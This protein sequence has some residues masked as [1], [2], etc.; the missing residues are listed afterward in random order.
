MEVKFSGGEV[1][2]AKFGA[3]SFVGR[4]SC[5]RS[6][7]RRLWRRKVGP[8]ERRGE[9]AREV[10]GEVAG[11]KKSD[12]FR[13]RF[14]LFKISPKLPE[15]LPE[16][17]PLTCFVHPQQGHTNSR[18]SFCVIARAHVSAS[19]STPGLRRWCWESPVL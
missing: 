7:L 2:F 15:Q 11:E 19:V 10:A 9:V 6:L 1:A 4:S 14:L 5:V 17:L 12:I 13:K 8:G 3:R 16:T 18:V